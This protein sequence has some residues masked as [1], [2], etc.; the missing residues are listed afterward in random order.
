MASRNTADSAQDGPAVEPGSTPTVVP[1]LGAEAQP[2]GVE[3]EAARSYTQSIQDNYSKYVAVSQVT[4][5]NAVALNPGDPV[6]ADHPYL[7]S[8]LD[9]GLV[10]TVGNVA[11]AAEKS[12]R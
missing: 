9:D 12:K 8:W 11:K 3:P 10:D 4:V 7:Q 6:P 1:Q 5:G 2:S